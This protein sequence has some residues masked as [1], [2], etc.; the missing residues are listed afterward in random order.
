M[1]A[2][3]VWR[4]EFNHAFC[5]S[6]RTHEPKLYLRRRGTRQV[7]CTRTGGAG[8]A[9]GAD[10]RRGCGGKGSWEAVEVERKTVKGS[11]GKRVREWG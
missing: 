1:A 8:G 5:T 2:V 9:D 11:R 7:N 3:R 4:E 6:S 10:G